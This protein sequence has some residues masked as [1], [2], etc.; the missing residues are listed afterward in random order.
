M[1]YIEPAL[2][3]IESA[4]EQLSPAPEEEGWGVPRWPDQYN[5]AFKKV[6]SEDFD[7]LGPDEVLDTIQSSL[8]ELY[9]P[10]E[11]VDDHY[12]ESL[13][14]R[15]T[16]RFQREEIRQVTLHR[17][18]VI[19]LPSSRDGPRGNPGLFFVISEYK[20]DVNSII[21]SFRD[22]ILE[23]SEFASDF[24]LELDLLT[25][26]EFASE[27]S[28][29]LN[30]EVVERDDFDNNTEESIFNEISEKL[31]TSIDSNVTLRFGEDDPE[32]FEYDLILYADNN[33]LLI[34][35]VKDASHEEAD[36]GKSELI[37][38]PRD[39]GN[40]AMS[41]SGPRPPYFRRVG[42]SEGVFVIVKHMDEDDFEQQKL[43]A[44]RRNINLLRYENGDYLDA[45]QDTFRGMSY[46]AL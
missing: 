38:T 20:S 25:G 27:M 30:A 42:G 13:R 43:M 8:H 45:L 9:S 16:R 4:G 26:E 37:D 7:F 22:E 17:D 31:T 3:N 10:I 23:F 12:A 32:V 21:Q 18:N 5:W 34:I 28:D 11:D 6:V 33:N 24:G 15:I 1:V 39:K 36:L 35:E 40:I 19:I 29:K 44:E 41:S 14:R 2:L 46:R